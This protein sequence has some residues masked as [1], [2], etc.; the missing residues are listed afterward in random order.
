M[1]IGN[2]RYHF[3][4]NKAG[5]E[6]KYKYMYMNRTH[7]KVNKES[8]MEKTQDKHGKHLVCQKVKN[9][10]RLVGTC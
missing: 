9:A 1:S 10:Q 5:R 7:L 6:G 8:G 4:K 2:A 3:G